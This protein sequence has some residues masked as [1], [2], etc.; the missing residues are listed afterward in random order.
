MQSSGA[1]AGPA[2]RPGA[3]RGL[4]NGR[5]ARSVPEA[6]PTLCST[7]RVRHL[8]LPGAEHS[9]DLLPVDEFVL[10]RRRVH[11]GEYLLRAGDPF[12]A[13]YAFRS[14]FF[15]SFA[16]TENGRTQVTAFP[17]AGDLAGMD[18]IGSGVHV[19]NLVALES[20]E[21]CVLPYSRLQKRI[22]RFPRLQYRVDRILSHEIVR[23]QDLMTLLGTMGGEAKVALFL[24][25]LASRFAARGCLSSELNLRMSRADIGSYL[26]LAL[27]TVSRIVSKLHRLGLIRK[28]G[29]EVRIVDLQGLRAI[30]RHKK[31]SFQAEARHTDQLALAARPERSGNIAQCRLQG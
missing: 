7:C 16:V 11:R 27:A 12:G 25:S 22:G 24:L 6:A 21:V 30:A 10:T 14:G 19:Q 5:S 13:L 2:W 26:S 31:D 3:A 17:M 15:K 1:Q 29:R 9:D 23:E 8:C 18:G 28:K 4:A 20:G